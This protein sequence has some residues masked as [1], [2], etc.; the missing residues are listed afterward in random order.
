MAANTL[1]QAPLAALVTDSKTTHTT[2]LKMRWSHPGKAHLNV[3]GP[4]VLPSAVKY[5]GHIQRG[6]AVQQLKGIQAAAGGACCRVEPAGAC[7]AG[8]AAAPRSASAS[9]PMPAYQGVHGSS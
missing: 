8:P 2:C 9:M 5:G 7:A 6:A 1:L 4:G 3:L